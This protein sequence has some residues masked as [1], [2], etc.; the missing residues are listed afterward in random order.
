MM[1]RLPS[2]ARADRR[3]HSTAAVLAAFAYVT[4]V[5]GSMGRLSYDT[6]A[7]LWLIPLLVGG[8]LMVLRRLHPRVG[9]TSLFPLLSAALVAKGLGTV[10]RY[11]VTYGVY[12]GSSDASVYHRTGAALARHYRQGDFSV[13]LGRGSASTRFMKVVTGVVYSVT[14]P[15]KIGG[16]AVF[17]VA[18]FWGLYLAFRAFQIAVPSGDSRRYAILIFFLPSMLFWPSSIGKEAWMTLAL[19]LCAYGA[20][21]LFSHQSRAL[22]WLTPGLAAAVAVRPHVAMVVLVALCAGYLAR[23]LRRP[24]AFGGRLSKIV[25]VAALATVGIIATQQMQGAL[26]LDN[27]SSFSEALDVAEQRTDEGGSSFDAARIR[28]PIDVPWATVT[29]L[30]RPFPYEAGNLQMLVSALEGLVLMGLFLVSGRRIA[31][32]VRFGLRNPYV[33]LVTVYSMVFIFAFSAFGNFGIVSRQRVQLF[34]FILILLC[35]NPDAPEANSASKSL[36]RGRTL[37]GAR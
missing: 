22:L 20:A 7:A 16:F 9:S 30:F 36:A 37:V 27:A 28:S 10:G 21:K 8:S 14:G 17:A 11:A 13:D 1:T 34:P 33:A 4:V 3:L 23:P 31:R 35:L 29:V 2:L 18:S 26:N 24:G 12:D 5:A 6:W 15:S 25:G 32:A 19:G